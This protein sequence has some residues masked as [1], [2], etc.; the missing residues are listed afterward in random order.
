MYN[1]I[2][3]GTL[4]PLFD[5]LEQSD[6]TEK[7]FASVAII[8]QELLAADELQPA[9][10]VLESSLQLGTDDLSLK[11]SVYSALS[12]AYWKTNNIK[13]ALHFMHQDLLTVEG[14]N[15]TNGICR[16]HGNLGNA[17]FCQNQLTDCLLYTSPSPRDKRQS[18]MPSSA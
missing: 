13:R 5:Q 17:Y 2:P 3:T 7:S 12:N 8:G 16:V 10:T 18:R 6:I 1:F 15:D 9:I 14:L 4:E 11:G